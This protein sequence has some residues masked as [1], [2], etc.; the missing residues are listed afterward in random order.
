MSLSA[1]LTCAAASSTAWGD[2]TYSF[3]SFSA[4]GF[5]FSQLFAPGELVGTATGV[6]VVATLTAS[7][8]FTYA[9]DLCV[10][11]DVIPLS[12]AG[13][14]QVGGFSD[15]SA[16]QRYFWTNGGSDAPGT[17][18]SS[19][20]NFL[21]PV[22]MAARDLSVYLGNGYGAANTSGTWTGSIT[23]HGVT[24]ADTCIRYRDFDGDGFGSANS[25]VTQSCSVVAGYVANN[26]DC[27]D[28]NA[29][30]N[31]NTTWYRD[32]DGDGLG[33]A[34]DGTTHQ[35]TQPTGYSLIN[36][37]N[38]PTVSNANQADINNNGVGDACEY[39]RG[40]LNLDGVVNAADFAMLLSNWGWRGPSIEDL[41]H[42]G[43][44]NG[45]DIPLLM[46]NWGSTP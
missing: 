5:Q 35:C 9:D 1:V 23:L 38:C 44:V 4:A 21:T 31:P 20:V 6:S 40:D 2:I 12:T 3:A 22:N 13:L 41:N 8:N 14:V 26:D 27:D 37:D 42:D 24:F 17:V 46:N 25:G 45:S 10:Y 33:A 19:T 29:S 36:G 16:S 43:I 15:L 32:T 11:L 28:N 7:T 18:V 30:I 39:A 34:A